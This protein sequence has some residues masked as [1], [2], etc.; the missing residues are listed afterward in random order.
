ILDSLQTNLCIDLTRIY[1]SGMSNGGGF[2]NLLACSE[3]T[4]SKFA[5]FAIVSAA[6]YSGTHPFSECNP[7]RKIPLITFH[8]TA[9]TTVPYDGRNDT[10]NA[11]DDTPSIQE[12]RDAWVVRNGCDPNAPRNVSDPYESVIETTWQC[13]NDTETMVI[14][15]EIEGG[16]HEW[17]ST[18]QT[19]FNATPEQIIPFFNQYSLLD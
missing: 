16:I 15:F 17:P 1:A 10:D 13:D 19:T 6:L 3:E 11:E 5:A 18:V 7:G 8:G 12:W 9:D 4:A 2:V 14:G